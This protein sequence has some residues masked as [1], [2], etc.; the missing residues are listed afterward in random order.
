MTYIEQIQAVEGV[1]EVKVN[2]ERR[3]ILVGVRRGKAW[4]WWAG[5]TED[6]A[7]RRALDAVRKRKKVT[8]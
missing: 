2:A 4:S 3:P 7:A 6:G 5:S 1:E 8:T